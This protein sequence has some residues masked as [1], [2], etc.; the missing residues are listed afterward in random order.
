[1]TPSERTTPSEPALAA[2]R[3]G[4]RDSADPRVQRTRQKLFDAVERLSARPGEVTV[5]AIVA[6]SGVS[7]ATFYTHFADIDELALRMQESAFAAIAASERDGH[8]GDHT[9]A[10][11]DSQRLLVEHYADHRSLY[12][13]VYRLPAGR[14]VQARVAWV[15]AGSIRSHIQ[16]T[17]ALPAGLDVDLAAT[18]IANA[19][20]GLLVS[21]VLGEVEAEPEQLAEHLLEL[22]PAWMHAGH[23]AAGDT[24]DITPERNTP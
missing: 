21:W 23:P 22:M 24:G 7:R 6:E 5:S 14:G 8:A 13:A 11:L 10:M 17:G 1:M 20:T 3:G 4:L 12:A 18:Y 2:V 9:A 16:D 15:M 19:A